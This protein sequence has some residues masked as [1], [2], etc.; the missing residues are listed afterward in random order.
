MSRSFRCL[1]ACSLSSPNSCYFLWTTKPTQGGIANVQPH[2]PAIRQV[3]MELLPWAQSLL[4]VQTLSPLKGS[5][6]GK[7]AKEDGVSQDLLCVSGSQLTAKKS[8][9]PAKGT[10][11]REEMEPSAPAGGPQGTGSPMEGP[12]PD[13]IC[14]GNLIVMKQTAR[15]GPTSGN[16]RTGMSTMPPKTLP[17]HAM[18]L[19]PRSS[20]MK[21]IG[22]C[23]HTRTHTSH[24][25][26]CL[27]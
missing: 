20:W 26:I 22:S 4:W 6:S 5:G 16:L 21:A 9:S 17:S 23:R 10:G 27:P 14:S 11:R 18:Q 12:T 24:T 15:L 1:N 25:I 19:E 7:K 8:S 3:M 2:P 13:F